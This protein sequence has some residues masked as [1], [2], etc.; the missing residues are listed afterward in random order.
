MAF[1]AL[2]ISF[3]PYMM[4]MV[5]YYMLVEISTVFLHANWFLIKVH[6]AHMAHT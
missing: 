6:T 5:P 3:R 2:L 4:N 1:M